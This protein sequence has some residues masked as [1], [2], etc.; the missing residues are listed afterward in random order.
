LNLQAASVNNQTGTI[1]STQSS[2]T[3]TSQGVLNNTSG[4][5][6]AAGHTLLDA[7]ALTNTSGTIESTSLQIQTHGNALNNQSGTIAATGSAS[8]GGGTVA[9][10]TG[11]LNNDAGLIQATDSLVIHTS[12]QTLTNTHSGTTSGIFAKGH[13]SLTTGDIANNGGF[14]ASSG[15]LTVSGAHIANTGGAIASGGTLAISGNALDNS[16]GGQLQAVGDL[17]VAVGVGTINNAAGLVHAN[18][19]IHL[20]AASINNSDTSSPSQGIEGGS[21]TIQANGINNQNGSIQADDLLSV[22]GFGQ[23][24][25]THGLLTSANTLSIQDSQA[26]A[27]SNNLGKTLVLT[28]TGG[29]LKA[30]QS[31]LIDSASL[32][33]DGTVSSQGNVTA[34]LLGDYTHTGSA[35]WQAD[36]ALSLALTDNFANTSTLHLLGDLHI[37]AANVSN[38]EHGQIAGSDVTLVASGTITNQGSVVG[39]NNLTLQAGQAIRN[40]GAGALLGAANSAGTLTLLAPVIENRDDTTATDATPTTLIY[41]MGNV[42]LAGGVDA[43]GALTRAK[44]ILNQSAQIE[45]GANMLLAANQI[46]N[47]RRELTVD[48]NFVAYGTPT[49]GQVVWTEAQRPALLRAKA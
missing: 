9:L 18:D 3:L 25:N 46:T 16:A 44:N 4:H 12:G 43:N 28:N 21:V 6:Q 2:L 40:T 10:Y 29:T 7:T 20:S 1:A 42:I 30:S 35:Q 22:T 45:S 36:G 32:S 48:S 38:T 24:N 11:A 34:K 15:N 26:S 49:S 19:H 31:V 8:A 41:G 13:A 47:T 39:T 5:L 27:T 37:D 17:S 33:F 14:L 23:L